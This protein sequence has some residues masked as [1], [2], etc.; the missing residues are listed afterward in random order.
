MK[1][2]NLVLFAIP[3]VIWG[4]TWYVITFQLGEVDPLLSVCYRFAF[5]GVILLIYSKV[6]GLKL[7]F[8]PGQHVFMA[9][10]GALLFGGNY[11]LVYISESY[12]T[13]GLVAIAF[14]TLIFMNILFNFLF[15][16]NPVNRKLI[17]GALLGVS[18]TIIIFHQELST[19][20]FEDDVFKG[21]VFCT[22][23][24][25]LASLGNIT[26]AFNQKQNLPVIQTNAYGM[27]Y[28]G[29]LMFLIALVSNK[30]LVIDTSLPYLASLAYLTIFGSI[31]A[32]S[33]YLTLVG[34]IG[35]DKAAYVIVSLPVIAIVISAIFEDFNVT[36]YTLTGMLLIVLGNG[37]ALRK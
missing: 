3:A 6:R 15:L 25:V 28:G 26:S 5:A 30:P 37:M 16:G 32:F 14:S 13:S 33:T 35:A 20:S 31:I 23:G 1:T 9:M 24:V 7:S 22:I 27:L 12:I 11:W 8:T 34:R 36:L 29:T 19:L 2:G 17:L 4:S 10:Q 21:L 18:G